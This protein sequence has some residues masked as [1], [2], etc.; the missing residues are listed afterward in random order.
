[1]PEEPD[2]HER[3]LYWSTRFLDMKTIFQFQPF[4]LYANTEFADDYNSELAPGTPIPPY[5]K[6]E[7]YGDEYCIQTSK[8]ENIVGLQCSTWSE[9]LLNDD[10][11][12][13]NIFPRLYACAERAANPRPTF[14]T[15]DTPEFTADWEAFLR[16]TP[17]YI[18]KLEQRNL[19]YRV[20][21]PGVKGA[22]TN[23]QVGYQLYLTYRES[24]IEQFGFSI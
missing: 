4:D 7:K 15:A 14:G 22:A 21:V 13:R 16:K 2:N 10:Q 1:M 23:T 12:T 8:P 11:L 5:Y 9:T 3:G 20:P 24:H 18:R 6:C 19:A 17:K